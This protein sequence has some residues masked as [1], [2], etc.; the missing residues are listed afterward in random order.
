MS[1]H[2]ARVILAALALAAS[3]SLGQAQAPDPNAY[4]TP[5]HEV[6]NWAKLPA[7]RNFGQVIGVYPARDGTHIWVFERCGKRY[8]TDSA[9]AP[10]D[11][12][13]ASGKLVKSFGAG[14]FVFP[15]G[16]SL[17]RNG[18]IWVTDADIKDGKGNQVWKLSSSGK[19]LMT[20]GKKGVA[21]SGPD[22]F[23]KPCDVAVA[24][25]G[26]IFVADGHGKND[27]IVKLSADGKF[28]K[29]WGKHG[30]GPG[31]FSTPHKLAIDSQGRLFVA[32]R[33]NNRLQLFD[34]DG[35][36][37]AEWRQFGKPSGIYIDKHDKMYVSDSESN[38]ETNPGFRRGIRIGSAKTGKVAAFIP[39]PK[40]PHP[41][42]GV[43]TG[44]FP[45]GIAADA[46]GNVYGGET[47]ENALVK[48]SS[49]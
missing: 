20:L 46:A 32:D 19:V 18:N 39:D 21:G 4:P 40:P 28:I 15:H 45:E 29:A 17:D 37:L 12:F 9:V 41:G 22:E 48:W 44:S 34:Q 3:A 35:K 5:Y 13:D 11:E 33:E 8:C 25:D 16:L 1:R 14:L 30:S 38:P 27:R 31:E 2:R 42:T 6:P 23:D 43:G 26:S 47:T 7:G 24:K 49:K 10:I 36:F